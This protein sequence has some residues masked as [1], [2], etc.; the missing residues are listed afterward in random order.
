MCI[1]THN[2]AV[3]LFFCSLL[4]QLKLGG[5]IPS[6]AFWIFLKK[7]LKAK[8]TA[9]DNIYSR[10]YTSLYR[11]V[12]IKNRNPKA[13]DI[14]KSLKQAQIYIQLL[15]LKLNSSGVLD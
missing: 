5:F 2:N 3:A 6:P 12:L 4:K 15:S 10:P 14:T 8:Q 11:R 9:V 1:I 7:S 13:I